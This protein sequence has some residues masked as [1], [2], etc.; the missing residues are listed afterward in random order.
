MGVVIAY[1]CSN[2]LRA[3]RD[4]PSRQI[5]AEV[6]TCPIV[7]VCVDNNIDTLAAVR[8]NEFDGIA[9]TAPACGALDLEMRNLHRHV[10]FTPDTNG[11]VDRLMQP[12]PLIA[13]MTRI[14]A[15]MSRCNLGQAD[16]FFGRR[17]GARH[18][19]QS[20]RESDS[21]ILHCLIDQRPHL[22]KFLH[23]WGA[24]IQAHHIS[25]HGIVPNQ[26]RNIDTEPNKTPVPGPDIDFGTA[27]VAS[28]DGRYAVEQVIVS[29]RQSL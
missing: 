10:G 3:S 27:A 22:F 26:G 12:F 9:N 21:T 2:F 7:R 18:I 15:A 14:Y 8:L 11:F 24:V 4:R 29:A 6:R 17:V 13:D 19:Q 5:D 20:G 16:D 25:A 1:A 23:R 28:N